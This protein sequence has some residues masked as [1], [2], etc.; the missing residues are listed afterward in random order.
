MALRRTRREGN[1]MRLFRDRSITTKLRLLVIMVSG[2][3]LLLA[4]TCFVLNDMSM[5][6]SAMVM[7]MSTVADLL[8]SN[9][10]AAL[11]FQDPSTATELLSSLNRQPAVESACIYNAAGQPFATYHQ[12]NAPFQPPPVPK[13]PGNRFVEGGYLDVAQVIAHDGQPIGT[14]YLHA[15]GDQLHDQLARYAAIVAVMVIVSLGTSVVLSWRFQRGIS[16][17]VLKLAEAAKRISQERNYGI[18]V[19]KTA[20]DE[21]GD[22]CDRFNAML[23]QI[24]QGEAA[25][26][27]AHA[28][29]EAKVQQRTAELS[30]ANEDLSREVSVRVQ[31]EQE[32]ESTH[33]KLLD[34]ARRAG[35]AEIATGILHNVG[36]VLNSIN[37]S[38]TLICDRV[39][40]S[41]VVDLVRMAKLVDRHAGDLG[42]FLTLDPKGK[43]VPPFLKLLATHLS[44]ERT[45]LTSELA[46]LA[47]NVEHVKIIVSTQQSYAGASGVIE[48]VDISTTLDDA[49]RLNLA[50]FERENITMAKEYA[51]IPK[52][53]LDKQKVLQ[54]LINLIKNAKEAFQDG[55]S[56]QDKRITVRT[57]LAPKG[58]LQIH[59]IDSGIGIR[60]ENLTRIFSHGFTTKKTGHGFGLHSCANAASEL[61]GSLKASSDGSGKGARFILEIPYRPAATPD[62]KLIAESS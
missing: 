32:L 46:S 6:R 36:N 30:R 59:I 37:V 4:T 52:V 61:G 8:G 47:Q 44:D 1:S 42:T 13:A 33:Q 38:T 9:S 56:E 18:R 14:I 16:A 62:A 41:K 26:H 35:M 51:D 12:Q 45:E 15:N 2:V 54:I 7:Q 28:D 23:Q 5:M 49:L 34:V 40:Q 58:M 21:L 50:S 43:Q 3:A 31:A 48:V 53:H 29:L 24:Q 27:K 55:G 10:T 11:S 19:V 25:I 39:R 60:T 17:P 57:L 20:N 22:L